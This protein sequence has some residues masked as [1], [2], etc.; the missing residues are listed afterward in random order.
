MRNSVKARVLVVLGVA[1]ASGVVWAQSE[2]AGTMSSGSAAG[3]AGGAA[4]G[5]AVGTAAVVAPA[6][7]GVAAAAVAAAAARGARGG[8]GN[9]QHAI[10]HKACPK[11]DGKGNA[12]C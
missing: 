9:S 10:T 5:A 1:I 8:G 7:L 4:S 12:S 6:A 3:T 2:T 11:K